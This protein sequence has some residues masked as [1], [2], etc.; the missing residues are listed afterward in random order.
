MS[1]TALTRPVTPSAVRILP[2]DRVDEFPQC[3]NAKDL[4]QKFFRL[5]LPRRENG[6]YRYRKAGLRAKP[7]TLVLFQS[8][9]V[10]I[11]SANLNGS[12]R[13]KQ[14]DKEGYK[15]ALYFDVSSIKVF[16]PVDMATVSAI[17]P[18]I[19]RLGRVKWNLNPDNYA[20]FEQKLK[21][22]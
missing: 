13:F 16:E 20:A 2:M 7:G 17:W 5:E 18:E 4:Q 15:G 11:A 21:Y 10:I 14:P 9:G 1:D 19:K 8:D 3:V 12:E 22:I 6:T